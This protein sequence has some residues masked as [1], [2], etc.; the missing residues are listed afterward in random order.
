EVALRLLIRRVQVAGAAHDRA[1]IPV[2][3]HSTLHY[4]RCY[5]RAEKGKQKVDAVMAQQGWLGFDEKTRN[6]WASQQVAVAGPL[7]LGPLFDPDVAA[8]AMQTELPISTETRRLLTIIAEESSVP[9]IGFF[10]LHRICPAN[11][12]ELR[13]KMDVI[14]RLQQQG[15]KAAST[16][17]RD[18][19]IR[20]TASFEQVMEAVR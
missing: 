13:R 20:T 1:M 15:S 12:L 14:R 19:A 18:T 8:K 4:I 2:Y 10:D 17:I 3:C 5:F 9:A 16:H 7:W 6:F 11:G